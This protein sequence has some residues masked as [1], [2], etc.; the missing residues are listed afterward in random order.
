MGVAEEVAVA[1]AAMAA[2]VHHMVAVVAIKEEVAATVLREEAG[3]A[4]DIAAVEEGLHIVR[5]RSVRQS[6]TNGIATLVTL[7]YACTIFRGNQG[8]T[9]LIL[10]SGQFLAN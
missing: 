10:G 6:S 4:A 7:P 5:T 9:K 8:Y 2:V 3:T 1:V